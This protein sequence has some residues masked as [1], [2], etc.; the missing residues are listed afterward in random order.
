MPS[1]DK[2]QANGAAKSLRSKTQA[3]EIPPSGTDDSIT[4]LKDDLSFMKKTFK[5]QSMKQTHNK[6]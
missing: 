6:K 4:R 2:R 5:S 3:D 1:G